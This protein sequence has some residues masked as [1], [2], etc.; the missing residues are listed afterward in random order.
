M[1]LALLVALGCSQIPR[2]AEEPPPAVP[3]KLATATPP[4]AVEYFVYHM[5]RGDTLYGLGKRFHVPWTEIAQTNDVRDLS[6]LGVGR[7]MLI[8]K[9][10]GVEAPALDLTPPEPRPAP[11]TAVAR[12]DLHRGKPASRFWWPTKG[13]ITRTFGTPLRG[14]PEAGVGIRAPAG[15]DVHAAEA[16]TVVASL[17]NGSAASS[18]W[19][20]VVAVAHS[21]GM[22][23]WYACLDNVSASKG[24]KVA[25]GQ[26]IGTVGPNGTGR[27]PELAFR[28]FRNDRAVDPTGLLP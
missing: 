5:Q 17:R 22:V 8:R 10:S 19:G 9:A 18:A 1:G 25:K 3:P 7:A 24:A 11:R 28:M 13:R 12:A 23:S 21:G 26:A 4:P 15:T 14:L 16:G 20:G 2:V 6:K 27:G